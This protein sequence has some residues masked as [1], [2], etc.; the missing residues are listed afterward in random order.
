LK[1]VIK[2]DVR[3]A[4]TARAVAR[5]IIEGLTVNANTC[6]W[7]KSRRRIAIC[8]KFI[9]VGWKKITKFND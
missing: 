3:V 8:Q 5:V 4:P 7:W 2:S 1:G 6:S 9:L